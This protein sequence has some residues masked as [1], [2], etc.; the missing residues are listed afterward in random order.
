ME[1][2]TTYTRRP[3]ELEAI[4]FYGQSRIWLALEVL[5]VLMQEGPEL[6]RVPFVSSLLDRVMAS[7]PVT[8]N[9]WAQWVA[10]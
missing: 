7:R 2:R 1:P 9:H 8:C 6:A 10:A 5:S 3:V 4:K